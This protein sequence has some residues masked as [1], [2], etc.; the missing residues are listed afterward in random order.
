MAKSYREAKTDKEKARGKSTDELSF[1]EA[2]TFFQKRGKSKGSSKFRWRGDVYNTSGEKVTSSS[3]GSKRSAPSSSSKPKMRTTQKPKVDTTDD[4]RAA[5]TKGTSVRKDTTDDARAARTNA[6]SRTKK[7]EKPAPKEY[8]SSGR[9]KGQYEMGR[10]AIEQPNY[11]G[12]KRR[13]STMQDRRETAQRARTA[14]SANERANAE[15]AAS[16]PSFSE[17]MNKK[18]RENMDQFRS[19]PAGFREAA[20]AEYDRMYGAKE[21]NKGGMVRKGNKDYKKSGM[22]Y[23]SAS[24]RG[25]K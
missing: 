1:D 5:R 19:D 13:T 22:F 15:R 10:R 3:G 16:A 24:P 14:K 25:Y 18:R 20:R 12:G 11:E 4:A 9:G 2:L 6:F 8:V 7:A 21:F 17:F 23:K